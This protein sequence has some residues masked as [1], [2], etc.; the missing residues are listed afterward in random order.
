[1]LTFEKDV[2]MKMSQ[3]DVLRNAFQAGKELTEAQISGQY[4]IKAPRAVI[5]SL[6]HEDGLAIYANRKVNSRGVE[7]TKYRLGNPS[8]ALVAAGYR[9]MTYGI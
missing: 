8:R 2:S 9:A 4:K 7:T 5:H 1:M 6:R 3:K